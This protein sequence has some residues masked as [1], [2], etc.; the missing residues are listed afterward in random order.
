MFAWDKT[1]KRW[2]PAHHPF[3]SL[4]EEDMAKLEANIDSVHDPKSPLG[5]NSRPG[6]RRG[7]ER[8]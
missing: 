7:A 4:H 2:N 3:T 1:E 6:L 8:N 5:R